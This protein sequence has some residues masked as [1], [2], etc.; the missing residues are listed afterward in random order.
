MFVP[1]VDNLELD[2]PRLNKLARRFDRQGFWADKGNRNA[3]F[4]EHLS[5]GRVIRKFIGFDMAAAGQ[6][7]A[8]LF[9]AVKQDFIFPD[10][11][12]G[13]RKISSE[14][15]DA[16]MRGMVVVFWPETVP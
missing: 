13:S 6:P 4:L 9:M 15:H 5:N 8:K 2:A 3:R 12:G 14:R 16:I 10:D 11:E 1:L 7:Y